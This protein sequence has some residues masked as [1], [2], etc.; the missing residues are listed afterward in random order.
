MMKKLLLVLLF[1]FMFLP[2]GVFAEGKVN[3]YLFR[4]DGCPHCEEFNKFIHGIDGYENK[5][6]VQDYEVWGNEKN[7]KMMEKIAKMRKEEVE[8]VPY[9]IIGDKAW[10]GYSS[11]MNKEIED[12]INKVY[13]QDASE[14]YDVMKE[15]QKVG[16]DITLDEED[17]DED[18]FE[19]ED[20]CYCD[21]EADGYVLEDTMIGAAILSFIAGILVAGVPLLIAVIV[22]IILLI[23]NKRNG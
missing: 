1:V 13:N 9:I 11:D 18:E 17:E 21:C 15:Y 8:G 22:L 12:Q 19:D 7:Y 23:K 3:V 20:D 4:G 16:D 2:V 10:V 14:R 6:M 5:V